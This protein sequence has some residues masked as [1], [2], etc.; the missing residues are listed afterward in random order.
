[1][2]DQMRG[3]AG[4]MPASLTLAGLFEA[5]GDP[6]ELIL[7]QTS[8]KTLAALAAS[9]SSLHA[10][11]ARQPESVWQAAA[12]AGYPSSHPARRAADVRAQLQ[13]QHTVAANIARRHYSHLVL[14]TERGRPSPDLSL[15]AAL[16]SEGTEVVIRELRTQAVLHSWPLPRIPAVEWSPHFV[17]WDATG[18]YLACCGGAGRQRHNTLAIVEVHSGGCNVAFKPCSGLTVSRTQWSP[19]S[20]GPTHLLLQ[21]Q[22]GVYSVFG[23]E[24]HLLDSIPVPEGSA[25]RSE[26]APC[27]SMLLCYSLFPLRLWLWRVGSGQGAQPVLLQDSP[28]WSD[29]WSAWGPNSAN[30]LLAGQGGSPDFQLVNTDTRQ[31]LKLTSPVPAT[32][33]CS[34]HCWGCDCGVALLCTPE[35][36][37]VSSTLLLAAL[38]LDNQLVVT[39]D[40]GPA[41]EQLGCLPLSMQSGRQTSPDRN[42]F[43]VLYDSGALRSGGSVQPSSQARC[44][45]VALVSFASGAVLRL[46]VPFLHFAIRWSVDGSK[47]LMSEW[48]WSTTNNPH[49]LIDFA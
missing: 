6:V 2:A 13:L 16:N 22:S 3:P 33:Y 46:D 18:R 28:D 15:Q 9:C 14:H 35:S 25:S 32:H 11:V 1:M 4:S 24:G 42:H 44:V 8:P 47:L 7:A 29:C 36:K 41:L 37:A 10:V 38:G 17:Q 49:V 48:N 43:A 45:A 27:A 20:D 12:R 23:A 19:P 21:L 39:H 31:A 5:A 40:L 26:W 34:S 30:L